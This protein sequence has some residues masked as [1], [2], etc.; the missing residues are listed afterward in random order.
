MTSVPGLTARPATAGSRRS[1]TTARTPGTDGSC[2]S[3]TVTSAPLSSSAATSRLPMK[4]DPPVTSTRERCSSP[5]GFSHSRYVEVVFYLVVQGFAGPRDPVERKL[6]GGHRLLRR[7]WRC[8]PCR[9][10]SAGEPVSGHPVP[11]RPRRSIHALRDLSRRAAAVSV[12]GQCSRASGQ[13]PGHTPSG[14]AN[15]CSGCFGPCRLRSVPAGSR[16]ATIAD[17]CF[18]HR[19]GYRAPAVHNYDVSGSAF[20]LGPPLPKVTLECQRCA[21]AGDAQVTPGHRGVAVGHLTP[22]ALERDD[23]RA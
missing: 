20:G 8:H 2:L 16:R 17:A 7:R 13:R 1:P 22:D 12:P 14:P 4:P 5:N 6:P 23:G 15:P 9:A 10:S 21:L 3:A 18:G 11:S 19:G